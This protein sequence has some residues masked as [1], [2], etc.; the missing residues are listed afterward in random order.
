MTVL[1][2]AHWRDIPDHAWPWRSFLPAEMADRRDG[3]IKI[4]PDF[5]DWLQG[6][7][8]VY[9]RPM[10]VSSGY[11]T[12]EHQQILPGNRVT[13]SH[14]DGMAADIRVYGAYALELINVATSN[15]VYGLGISQTGSL[16]SRYVHLDRW[17]KAPKGTRPN[18]WSY[19]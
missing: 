9:G 3:S 4:V 16:H 10:I 13:G 15:G 7:R 2:F 6:I 19:V 1:T 8:Y 18:L 14:V 12:P 5:M 17:E 11:R